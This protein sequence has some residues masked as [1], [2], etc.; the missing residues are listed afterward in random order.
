MSRRALCLLALA[1]A[2]SRGEVLAS[3]AP[4]QDAPDPRA[5]ARAKRGEIA[6]REATIPPQC[7]AT[8]EGGANP[9]WVCHTRA[10]GPNTK[11]DADLQAEA[12]FSAPAST[13]RWTNLFADRTASIAA[14]GDEE[15]LAWIRQ[16]NYA[17][18][19]EALAN[20][21]DA[22]G[23]VPDLD[24]AA[25]FDAHGFANDGSGWRAYRYKPFPGAF[26][27]SAGSAGDAMIRL[28]PAFRTSGDG[29]VS[30]AVTRA[31]L[32]ILDAAMT[33]DPGIV[34]AELRWPCELIDEIA[35]GVDLDR[36]GTQGVATTIVGLPERY[37]GGAASAS[38][39]REHY[40]EGTELLHT[41]RY[42]DPDSPSM[43]SAR[44]KELRWAKKVEDL[45]DW[46]VLAAYA[47]EHDEKDEGKLPRPA[48]SAL[49]GLRN[50]LGWQLQGYIED[51]QGRLRLQTDEEHLFCMGCH[52]GLGI[53]VDATFSFPRKP[54]G[55]D[56]WGYQELR[57]MPDAPQLGHDMPELQLYLERARGADDFRGDAALVERLQAPGAA[58]LDLAEL[59]RPDRD[60][61]LLLA[62]AYL[63][64]VR[65]QS[66]D[67]GRDATVVPPM[68]VHRRVE[69]TSTGLAEARRVY[70]DAQLRL[71]WSTPTANK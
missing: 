67:R 50:D 5:L 53:T 8:T 58:D 68:N 59:L 13:N 9:C 12:I 6:N 57:G 23:F 60:R 1:A 37:V 3:G 14:I 24:L 69:Q 2:C 63:V 71:D 49:S 35:I 36:D 28:P 70:G 56:G 32:A 27:P 4:A 29:Q 62:K 33:A 17:A 16:D 20:A 22:L 55:P 31:N 38:V 19:R 64:I 45:D 48:G 7:Y 47:H 54:P 46:A 52:G 10:H 40:P 30:D 34:A 26:L 21:P 66:F 42:V 18:L 43:F 41:V 44:L 51:E 39:R 15:I 65:E 61:A 11:D 25:G